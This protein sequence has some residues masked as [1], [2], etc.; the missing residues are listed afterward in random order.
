MIT[1]VGGSAQ[2]RGFPVFKVR[3]VGYARLSVC[4]FQVSHRWNPRNSQEVS[5]VLSGFVTCSLAE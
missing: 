4:F 1:L 3:N 2:I 5:D